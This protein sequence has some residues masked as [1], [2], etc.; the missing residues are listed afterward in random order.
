MN[1]KIRADYPM[2]AWS[3]RSLARRLQYFDIKYTDYEVTVGEIQEAVQ[4]ELQGP[5]KLLGYR[6]MQQK[7]REIHKL[8]VPRD[9]VYGMM[10]QEDPEGL[11]CRGGVGIPKR[12]KRLN[13]FVSGGPD[14]TLSCDGHD[15]LC[16]YQKSMFPLCVYGGMDTYSGR[17]NFLRVWTTNNDPKVVGRFYFEYL[18]ECKETIKMI[19]R[20]LLMQY[21][22]G[23][24]LRT[25][26]SGGGGNF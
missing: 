15:K 23:L 10:A 19:L 11:E 14:Y 26:L 17:I 5:G 9:V 20:S 25:R 18:C 24:L 22:M 3:L 2:Y 4:E 8:N 12:P 6:G 13:A 1:G 7:V 16:G 21:F